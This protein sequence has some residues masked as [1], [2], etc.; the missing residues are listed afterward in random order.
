MP[1]ELELIGRVALAFGLSFAIG[2]ERELRRG[3]AG[4]RTYALIGT[5]A[6]AISTIAVSKSAGNAIAGVVTGVGF[7]GA[8]LVFRQ[9]AGTLR[10]ITS[11]AAV[12]AT[13]SIG[14]VAGA[15]YPL[16]AL[17]TA[18][19]VLFLLELRFLPGLSMLD[20]RRYRGS[21]AGDDDPPRPGRRDRRRAAGA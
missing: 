21:L 9:A 20:A 19:I 3:P 14:V 1:S 15:G 6:A 11:A 7:I 2:F 10:G 5:A 4:D 8:A 12:L 18:G 13:T 17:A 16:L